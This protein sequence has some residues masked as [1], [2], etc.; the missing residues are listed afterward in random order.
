MRVEVSPR[1]RGRRTDRRCDEVVLNEA[2]NVVMVRTP[3]RSGEIVTFKELFD[4]GQRA[5]VVGRADE[6]RVAELAEQLRVERSSA[7]ATSC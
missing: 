2:Y 1:D 5:L 6:E 4:D 7:P 3:E